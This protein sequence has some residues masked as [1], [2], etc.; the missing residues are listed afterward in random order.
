MDL[1]ESIALKDIEVDGACRLS[2][3]D[4]LVC[5]HRMYAIRTSDAR[6]TFCRDGWRD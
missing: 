2:R 4:G 6:A 5:L 3:V 1:T